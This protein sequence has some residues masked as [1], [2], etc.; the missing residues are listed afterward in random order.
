MPESLQYMTH[1]RHTLARRHPRYITV[2][3]RHQPKFRLPPH[4]LRRTH[5]PTRVMVFLPRFLLPHSMMTMTMTFSLLLF[6]LDHHRGIMMMTV[7]ILTFFDFSF[8][9][10]NKTIRCVFLRRLDFQDPRIKD[11]SKC[12]YTFL[13]VNSIFDAVS[14]ISLPYQ[15]PLPPFRFVSVSFVFLSVEILPLFLISRRVVYN[16]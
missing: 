14:T 16:N 9:Y 5:H 6:Q 11:Y 10:P 15:Y 13:F 4:S 1:H 8:P 3:S 2:F 7:R 12:K